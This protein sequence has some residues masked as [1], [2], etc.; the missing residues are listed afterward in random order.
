MSSADTL[1]LASPHFEMTSVT[2][3]EVGEGL[4]FH[5]IQANGS[6][7][8]KQVAGNWLAARNGEEGE[9][10]QWDQGREPVVEGASAG[11]DGGGN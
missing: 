7:D 5:G 1:T 8:S 2:K 6:R 3:R 9:R 4:H 11:T 10:G